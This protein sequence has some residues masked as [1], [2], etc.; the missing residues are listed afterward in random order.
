M[1]LQLAA[2]RQVTATMVKKYRKAGRAEKTA[3]LDHLCQVNG[4]H[5]N[6]ARKALRVAMAGP[7]APRRSR[8]PVLRYGPEVIEALVRVWAV[9][10]GPTFPFEYWVSTP[11]V[12][13]QVVSQTELSDESLPAWRRVRRKSQRRHA[14][15]RS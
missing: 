10:D 8:A 3:I 13:A 7:P 4:W 1:E 12:S 11:T 14:A 15:S 9:L 2:R 6:H 5:R